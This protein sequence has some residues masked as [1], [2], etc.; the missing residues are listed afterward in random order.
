MP[1]VAGTVELGNMCNPTKDTKATA[2]GRRPFLGLTSLRLQLRWVI[3]GYYLVHLALPVTKASKSY[4]WTWKDGRATYYGTD[5]WS[6]HMGSCG[7]GYIYKDEPLGW[8]VAAMTDVSPNYGDSCGTCYE[9]SCRSAWIS[10]NYGAS[11]DRTQ[12]CINSN[13]VIVRITDTCPCHYPPNEYSNK[14]WCCGDMEHFDLSAWAFEKIAELRWGVIGLKYRGPVPCDYKPSNPAADVPYPS[15]GQDPPIGSRPV[16]DWPEYTKWAPAPVT[17]FQDKYMNGWG[18]ASWNSWVQPLRDSSQSGLNG[19]TGLC[20]KVYSQGALA[21][22]TGKKA[23]QNR[24]LLRFAVYVGVTGLDGTSAQV[25]NLRLNIGG[26]K[27]SCTSISIYSVRPTQ[28]EPRCTYCA[29]YFYIWE[30]YLVA[31]AGWSPTAVVNTNNFNGCGWQAAQDLNRIEFRND[32]QFDQWV[33][34]DQV[35]LV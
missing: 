3:T 20:A 4:D 15:P 22:S 5:A 21:M 14:R 26:Q 35:Q 27:G 12:S 8:D 34:V 16:R 29:D 19:S 9:V 17:I 18:D 24:R 25:P 6:I 28:F 32:G 11:L 2:I 13:S 30:V 23:F 31:F 10:D 7:Y 33:C 1:C